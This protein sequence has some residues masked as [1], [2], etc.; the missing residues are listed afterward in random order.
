MRDIPATRNGRPPDLR[1]ASWHDACFSTFASRHPGGPVSRRAG[2]VSIVQ[3]GRDLTFRSLMRSPFRPVRRRALR[4]E[5]SRTSFAMLHVPA[6]RNGRPPDLRHASWH[7]ACFSTFASRHPGGP[8]SRRAGYVSIVQ[9]GRDLTFR[10]LM[11]SPF[12]PVRRRALR[13]EPSRTS[14]A[15]LHVPATR[16]GRPPAQRYNGAPNENIVCMFSPS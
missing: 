1:H 15:M 13:V 10:S 4:V 11:R 16:N 2:Y 6:T 3:I 8:G 5:P 12:R 14:F 7:D 9:I